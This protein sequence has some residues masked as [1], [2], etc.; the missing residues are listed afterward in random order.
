MFMKKLFIVIASGLFAVQINAQT[1]TVTFQPGATIGE[2]AYIFKTDG[3]CITSLTYP[4]PAAD[5]NYANEP[6]LNFSRWTYTSQGCSEGTMSSVIRFTELSTLPANVNIISAQLILKTPPSGYGWRGNSKYPNSPTSLSN[7]GMLKL[8]K[9]GSSYAWSEQTVTWNNFFLLNPV[10]TNFTPVSIP[11][12]NSEY[13]WTTTL[14]VTSMVVQLINDI[15]TYGAVGNNGFL[16]ELQTDEIYRCQMFASS[17]NL[18][19]QSR[20]KLVI[21]YGNCD[22]SFSYTVNSN[23]ANNY[24]FAA[25]NTTASSYKW[26]INGSIVD[27]NALLNYQFNTGGDYEICLDLGTK[28]NPCVECL[29]ICVSGSTNSISPLPSVPNKIV[30]S[31]NP[32]KT[33]WNVKLNAVSTTE[34]A[35]TVIDATGKVMQSFQQF[36]Q[37]GENNIYINAQPLASGIYMLSIKGKN[38]LSFQEKIIKY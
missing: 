9:S 37:N 30:I 28:Q 22:A 18:H 25:N 13:N 14:D 34:A 32:T 10:N 7:S 2:D 24:S 36:I 11:E 31:P 15:N 21:T 4:L 27:S 6:E 16:L 20:P 23:N 26:R 1:N 35:I 17:D 8:I 12:S 19:A 5:A 3:E 29:N 33:G 38:G